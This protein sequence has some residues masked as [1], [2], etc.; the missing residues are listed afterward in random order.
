MSRNADLFDLG[1]TLTFG[2]LLPFC[3]FAEVIITVLNVFKD[4]VHHNF[5]KKIRT[6]KFIIYFLTFW[7]DFV[8]FIMPRA[9]L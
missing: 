3:L 9:L 8:R 5:N 7:L 4:L 1:I 6:F 2:M